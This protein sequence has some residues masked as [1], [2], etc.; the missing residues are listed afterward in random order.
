MRVVNQWKLVPIRNIIFVLPVTAVASA[1]TPQS[2]SAKKS[3]VKKGNPHI[4]VTPKIVT[5]KNGS[6]KKI[7]KKVFWAHKGFL[8]RVIFQ[9]GFL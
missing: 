1:T 7:L 2:A 5:R 3:T 8:T 6:Q 4:L 9:L